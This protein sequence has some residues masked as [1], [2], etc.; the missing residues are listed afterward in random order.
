MDAGPRIE[1]DRLIL[2]AWTAADRAPLAA[3][4]ADPEVMRDYGGP[5]SR[6]DSDA[7]LDRYQTAVE[8]LG[9]GRLA[10]TDRAGDFLGYVGVMPISEQHR[11]AGEGVEIG[12]RLVR[13]AW[14]RGFATEAAR[15][16]LDHGFVE[17]GFAEVLA[18]TAPDNHRSLAVMARV[19][20]VRQ[21]ER[22]FVYDADGVR[23]TA[24]VFAAR[25]P[26]P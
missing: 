21:P 5:L 10:V 14:G 26:A 18:Y 23:F 19:G 12:W 11:A 7:K 9:Y 24:V 1:T 8:R 2:R 16:A 15:A 3:M 17:H 13:S 20:L 4:L 6:A 25:R 22:D